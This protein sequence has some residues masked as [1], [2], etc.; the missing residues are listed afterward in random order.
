MRLFQ[1]ILWVCAILGQS[2]QFN[3]AFTAMLSMRH[4]ESP[5]IVAIR[6]FAS[7]K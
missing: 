1:E 4:G 2:S 6:D 7:H 5:E 3:D